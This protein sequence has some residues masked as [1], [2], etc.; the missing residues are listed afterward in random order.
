MGEWKWRVRC[1]YNDTVSWP[2]VPGDLAIETV[3][4]DDHSKDMEVATAEARGDVNV[5]VTLLDDCHG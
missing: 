1:T 3:H 4:R 2:R 5:D